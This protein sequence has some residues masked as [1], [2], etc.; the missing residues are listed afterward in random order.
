MGWYV[1]DIDKWLE[2]SA[3]FIVPVIFGLYENHVDFG[4]YPNHDWEGPIRKN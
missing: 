4:R 3:K 1:I 2:T